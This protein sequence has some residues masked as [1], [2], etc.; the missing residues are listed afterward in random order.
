MLAKPLQLPPAV[1]GL[2]LA[3][4][5]DYQLALH[6]ELQQLARLQTDMHQFE[7]IDFDVDAIFTYEIVWF[8]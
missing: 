4:H 8:L 2:K 5:S 1:N 7:S 6:S 3:L